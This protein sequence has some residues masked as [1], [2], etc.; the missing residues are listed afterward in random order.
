MIYYPDGRH[1]ATFQNEKVVL[2]IKSLK[3]SPS[4]QFIC[5]GGF[6]EKI[7]LLNHYTW[8]P[9]IEFSHPSSV[10]AHD[11]I[12]YNEVAGSSTKDEANWEYNSERSRIR[13]MYFQFVF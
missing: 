13:C 11:I 4:G 6:D 5:L 8:K 1:V 2:G 7:R 3:W 9:L 12:C 10:D